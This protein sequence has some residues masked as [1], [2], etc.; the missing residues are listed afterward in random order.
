MGNDGN[1]L[2]PDEGGTS[3]NGRGLLKVPSRSSSQQ[4]NQASTASTG[5]SG[6]TATDPR[7][8]IDGRSK[9][10]RGSMPGRQRN[11]SASTHRSGGDSERGPNTLGNS[12]PSSPSTSDQKRRRKKNGGLLSLLGCCGVPDT[13]TTLEEGESENVHKIEKLP[14]RPVTA[15]SRPQAAAEQQSGDP[16]NEKETGPTGTSLNNV[17]NQAS[18]SAQEP[19]EIL[20][21]EPIQTEFKQ[22]QVAPAVVVDSPPHLSANEVETREQT[23]TRDNVDADMPDAGQEEAYQSPVP[24]L[25]EDPQ[26]QT[27][28]PPPPPPPSVPGPSVISP[29]P[30]TGS[31]PSAP[32]PQSWLLPSIAH[33]HKGRKCLVLDLDETLVHSSF[34]VSIIITSVLHEA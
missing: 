1:Q 18:S 26:S 13:A 14:Q 16:L 6:A 9:E 8:S 12:Q 19:E 33:E 32:E 28:P 10:S 21:A 30:L 29:L 31:N 22:Q 15:K 20:S 24:Q 3:K 5:L 11:G 27:I 23:E 25:T 7:S 2:S 4:R 34:K 17:E